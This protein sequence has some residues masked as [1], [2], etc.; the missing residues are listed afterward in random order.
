MSDLHICKIALIHS[1]TDF[2]NEAKFPAFQQ[3]RSKRGNV[4]ISILVIPNP[5]TPDVTQQFPMATSNG[6]L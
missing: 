4:I 5:N 3:K 2:R 1:I 6:I